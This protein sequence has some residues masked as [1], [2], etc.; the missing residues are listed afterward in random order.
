MTSILKIDNFGDISAEDDAVLEYFIE[1]ENVD[2]VKNSGKCLILGRK[3]SG[4]TAIVRYFSESN[5]SDSVTSKALNLRLYPWKV[6]AALIDDGVSNTEAYVASW[7]Y[8]ICVQIASII[9]QNPKENTKDRT[10]LKEFFEKNYGSVNPGLQEIMKIS[11][12]SFD[13]ISFAP[14]V[15]GNQLGSITFGRKNKRFGTEINAIT[16]AIYLC[17]MRIAK[18]EKHDGIFLHFDELDRGLQKIDDDRKNLLIGLVIAAKEIQKLSSKDETKFVPIIYLRTDIWNEL[19]FSDKNKI[20]RSSSLV[21]EWDKETLLDL[22]NARIKKIIGSEFSWNEITNDQLMR[23]SQSKWNHV[24]ARTLLRPRDVI[25]FCNAIA[26]TSQKRIK[27]EKIDGKEPDLMINNEDI[28]SAR[29]DYSKY[30]KEELDDEINNHWVCWSEALLACSE[31]ATETFDKE[32]FTK[33]YEKI[34]TANNP[35][36]T[37]EA[38]RL[39]HRFSVIGYERRSGYGGSGWAFAYNQ[40]DSSWD[41]KSTRF[42]VHSGLKEF[43]RLK[44]PR[45]S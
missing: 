33:S 22:I 43:A 39:L 28:V 26:K 18:L 5:I 25:Q 21:L 10:E 13:G 16:D 20:T 35:V 8:F 2:K 38:L 37:D 1:T 3:G 15:L 12:L 29:T 34:K 4:K 7:R 44:E 11:S 6:H 30:L 45:A 36:K 14:S 17:C 32:E 23:G 27:K 9:L 24:I 42:K 31:I 41:N 19:S 40:P